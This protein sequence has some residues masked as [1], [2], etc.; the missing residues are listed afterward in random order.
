[1]YAQPFKVFYCG[2]ERCEPGHSFGPAIR[3]QYL[4]HFVLSGR[5][6][7]HTGGKVHELAEGQA[8]LIRPGE[9]TFYQADQDEPWTYAWMA[10]AGD[11]SDSILADV[12]FDE[13]EHI[14]SF[15]QIDLTDRLLADL[16]QSYENPAEGELSLSGYF[17]LIMSQLQTTEITADNNRLDESSLLAQPQIYDHRYLARAKSFLRDNFAYP[18]TIT[19]L[20]RLIG[21][22]RTYLYRIFMHY[23]NRS[24]KQ[25]LTALRIKAAREMLLETDHSLAEIA[26]SCGFYD[27]S[28]F[29]RTFADAEGMTPGQYRKRLL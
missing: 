26:L 29:C 7:F 21:I 25:Y 10:F 8:F 19:N 2:R 22:D 13:N 18:I 9:V 12:G 11:Q 24:P 15:S 23:E 5:G 3:R 6:K 28:A 17:Y 20:A 4:I 27:A 1:M 16:Q 14:G